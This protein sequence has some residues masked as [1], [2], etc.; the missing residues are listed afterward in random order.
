MGYAAAKT[1]LLTPANSNR[2]LH[3]TV[4]KTLAPHCT[5]G[6][7]DPNFCSSSYGPLTAAPKGIGKPDTRPSPRPQRSQV[8]DFPSEG[9]KQSLRDV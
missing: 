3:K 8:H 7:I 9:T 4:L 2:L 5:A 6:I 1:L